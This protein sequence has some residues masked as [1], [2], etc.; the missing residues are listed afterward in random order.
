[1]FTHSIPSNFVGGFSFWKWLFQQH[2][3]VIGCDSALSYTKSL[4]LVPDCMSVAVSNFLRCDGWNE[5]DVHRFLYLSAQSPVDG[6]VGEGLGDVTLSEK[7]CHWGWALKFQKTQA[8]LNMVSFCFWLVS[9]V[10]NSQLLLQR[11]IIVP[12]RHHHSP[13]P[14][15]TINQV[16]SF[17]S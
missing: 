14:S 15:R 8:I 10:V 1:M 5:S 17:L 4:S 6:T 3:S 9:Q 7:V 11:P 12:S 13:L 2:D 16:K